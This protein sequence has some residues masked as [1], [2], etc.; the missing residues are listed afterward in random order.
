MA[1]M[2][3]SIIV[4]QVEL[5][6]IE[7]FAAAGKAMAPQHGELVVQPLIERLPIIDALTQLRVQLVQLLGFTRVD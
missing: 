3:A 1:A 5:V 4:Q 6:G 2:S 7:L